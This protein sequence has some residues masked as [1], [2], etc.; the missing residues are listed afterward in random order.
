VDV[1]WRALP[2]LVC[3]SMVVA[4]MSRMCDFSSSVLLRG[5]AR[6]VDQLGQQ[7]R[8][9]R[10]V[11]ALLLGVVQ[12]DVVD[13]PGQQCELAALGADGDGLVGFGDCLVGLGGGFVGVPGAEGPDRVLGCGRRCR[14]I[15]VLPHACQFAG[16]Q[17]CILFLSCDSVNSHFRTGCGLKT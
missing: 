1:H 14:R 17:F 7:D 4:C 12:E 13:A 2:A 16:V 6:V 3:H 5:E 10:V 9:A 11:D 8:V 15:V